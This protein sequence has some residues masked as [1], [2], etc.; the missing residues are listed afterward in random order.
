M[1]KKRRIGEVIRAA[2]LQ[3]GLSMRDLERRSGLATGEISQI[4]T[5]RRQDPGFSVVLK[6]ARG[7]GVSL[8]DLAAAFEGG[9]VPAVAAEARSLA[10][11]QAEL[12]RAVGQHQRLG[13]SLSRAVDV[14]GERKPKKPR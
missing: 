7:I 11:A 1:A 9:A 4:E 2:R 10:K 5:G 12:D 13:A 8:D 6:V 14:L 3:A